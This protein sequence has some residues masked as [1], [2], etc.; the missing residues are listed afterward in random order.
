MYP[1]ESIYVLKSFSPHII[2]TILGEGTK[3]CVHGED[4]TKGRNSRLRLGVGVICNHSKQ[5]VQFL[6]LCCFLPKWRQI[7][8]FKLVQYVT[9]NVAILYNEDEGH[10]VDCES[11]NSDANNNTNNSGSYQF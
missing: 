10:N 3:I 7:F 2:L 6:S 9:I 5:T 1:F 4:E 8:F 11:N